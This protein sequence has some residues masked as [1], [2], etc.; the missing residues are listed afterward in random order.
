MYKQNR[1]P[2]LLKFP[3]LTFQI[4]TEAVAWVSLN[5]NGNGL[6]NHIIELHGKRE[7]KMKGKIISLK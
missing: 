6:K 5:S 1:H 7:N 3:I 4:L 2:T